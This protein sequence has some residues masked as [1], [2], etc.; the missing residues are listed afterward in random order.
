ME[1]LGTGSDR[2]KGLFP[3]IGLIDFQLTVA[4]VTVHLKIASKDCC[5]DHERT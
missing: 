5:K 4:G 2:E 3:D 1:R